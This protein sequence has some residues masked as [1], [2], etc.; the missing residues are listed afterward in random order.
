MASA[1]TFKGGIHPYYGKELSEAI[2]VKVMPAPKEIIIPMNQS[3]GAP[4][5][6]LVAVGDYV[7]MGQKI[8]DNT[9]A[10]NAA[11]VH[12][13]VSGFVK[14][15]EKRPHL[16]GRDVVSVI[17]ENDEK[18][19][20]DPS[21]APPKAYTELDSAGIC[22]IVKEA[23]I[24]GMGGAAFPTHI[25]IGDGK[26]RIGVILANG[27][28]CEPYLTADHRVMLE[29]GEEL[30]EGLKVVL[31]SI[32][33]EKAIIAIEENK[34]DAVANMQKLT[35]GIDNIEVMVV[36][37]KYPQGAKSQLIKACLNKETPSGGRSADAGVILKNVGTIATI[38]ETFKTG[39]PL[40][41]RI[42]TVTGKGIKNPAN[43]LVRVGTKIS[44]VV[45]FCGGFNEGVV[46]IIAGGP[47]MGQAQAGIDAPIMK[48]TSGVL[49]LTK[50]DAPSVKET[51]CIRC[52]RC[53]EACPIRLLPLTI[54]AYSRKGD[55]DGA[56]RY[57]AA[58]CIECGCCS[59]SCPAK[60]RLT[61]DIRLAKTI[62]KER[63][64]PA[65][66]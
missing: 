29:R 26:G 2:A 8:G 40:F 17:I 21:I 11:P 38:G 47:M 49:V 59:F 30:V 43:L 19:A 16:S 36:E 56:A 45:E 12:A 62:I 20:L 15:I 57:H 22:Q 35:E 28:E 33:S 32:G 50:A 58:D 14:A 63:S 46:K 3:L 55:I 5:E 6:V 37:A 54:A 52:S 18:D 4:C 48:G 51:A 44:D 64:K 9:T 41:Q 66:C 13:S 42:I 34:M 10:K 1:K 24:V 60:R 25:A 39:M 27:A 53:V 31:K 61:E 7:Y 23:G 65:A